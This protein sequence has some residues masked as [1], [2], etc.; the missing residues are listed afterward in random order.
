MA[1]KVPDYERKQTESLLC[2]R[3]GRIERGL[4]L[5][6]MPAHE[7]F[8]HVH[9]VAVAPAMQANGINKAEVVSVFGSESLLSDICWWCQSA[10]VIVADLTGSNADLMY[11]LG[12]CHGLRRCPLI[13]SQAAMELPFNLAALRCISYEQGAEGMW[14]LRNSLKRAIRAF[15]AAS[16]SGNDRR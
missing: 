5:F 2:S 12:L 15:L 7:L 14:E 16:R 1:G 10:E 13:I 3:N 4:G 6:L 11:V 8:R 9:D